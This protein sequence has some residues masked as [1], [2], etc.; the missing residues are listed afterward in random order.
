MTRRSRRRMLWLLLLPSPLSVSK[1]DPVDRRAAGRLRKRE[2]RGERGGRG[3]VGMNPISWRRE[4]LV[5]YDSLNILWAQP[6]QPLYQPNPSPPFLT[7]QS[8]L[9][10]TPT[11]CLMTRGGQ[12]HRQVGRMPNTELIPDI[13]SK[14]VKYRIFLRNRRQRSCPLPRS[15]QS[16]TNP[17]SRDQ[18][19]NFQ[20]KKIETY[21]SIFSNF[22][23][24]F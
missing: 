9:T 12:R 8:S 4:S 11:P 17:I 22:E 1:L 10:S 14:G 2:G 16:L 3:G 24:N 18:I 20:Y 13:R 15:F 5:L 23:H 19:F 21:T 6:S 7:N